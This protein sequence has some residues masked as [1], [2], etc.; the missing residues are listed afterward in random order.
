[1][2]FTRT[3]IIHYLTC[4]LLGLI[5]STLPALGQKPKVWTSSDIQLA[6]QKLDVL[7]TVLYVAAHP[8]DE[9]TRLITWLAN[10]Q[11]YRTGY[12]SLTRG[13]G[14][15]NLIGPELRER[16]GLIRTQELLQARQVDG[17]VQFFT[18]AN[19]FGFSKHP[20][21]TFKIWDKEA[22]LAD[23][24]WVIRKFKP[25]VIIT[26]FNTEPGV[27]HGH[28]TAS[29][30]LAEEAFKAAAD[31]KRFPEQLKY[32]QPWQPKRLLWNTSSWFYRGRE[33]EF[34]STGLMKLTIG[35]YNP[36]LGKSYTE[37]AA[38]S[39]SMHRSQ[40]FGAALSRENTTE[41]LKPIAGEKPN[42]DLF[43]GIQTNWS[44][45]PGGEKIGALVQQLSANF[46]HLAPWESF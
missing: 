36:L 35:G 29:A 27:T 25:D 37:V 24:V 46:K 16:L 3:T 1:M 18:R 38:E 41:L 10:D 7:G 14:G 8:D 15:Q 17:G 12:L 4:L 2:A 5:L 33:S 31:P 21:E 40:G 23:V 43:S 28:H 34:D 45:V 22:V 30:I 6:L 39:R 42:G 13:D 9:N 44:R 20:D 11:K 26:R 19:D 32:L